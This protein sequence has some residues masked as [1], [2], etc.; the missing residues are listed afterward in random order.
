MSTENR[1]KG[2]ALQCDMQGMVEKILSDEW[3]IIKLEPIGRLFTSLIDPGTRQKSLDFIL[4]TKINRI[5]YDYQLNITLDDVTLTQYFIGVAVDNKI[6]IICANNQLEAIEY[7][8]QLQ[9]INNEQANVIRSLFKEKIN[10]PQQG[11]QDLLFNNVSKLNNELV[12]LQRQLFKKNTELEKLNEQK[13]QFLGMAAHDLRNPLNIILGY[14]DFL[15]TDYSEHLNADMNKFI[16]SIHSSAQYM[17]GLIEDLLDISKI[18]SGNLILNIESYDL[19]GQLQYIIELNNTIAKRKSIRID[20]FI[21]EASIIINADQQ[22]IEQV[23]NNLLNNAIKFSFPDT[24]VTVSCERNDKEISISISDNGPGIDEEDMKKIFNPYEKI[25][26]TGTAGEKGTGL[27]LT[28]VKR[29]VEGHKGT[30]KAES[31][32]EKGS[33]FIFT[34]PLSMSLP[35]Q[36]RLSL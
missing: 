2:F 21:P 4:D 30:I 34:L 19:I 22:K 5:T 17:L 29:I 32:P 23:L 11:D 8:N 26:K 33:T 7:T 9:Q 15:L 20:L 1:Q 27:G 6:I 16:S 13:N 36:D 18:E 31:E 14:S 24:V 28:I 25:A 3:G 35:A 10:T 12:N